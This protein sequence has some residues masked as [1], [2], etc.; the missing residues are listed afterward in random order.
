[1]Y[2]AVPRIRP[3]AV[4]AGEVLVA[5]VSPEDDV[6]TRCAFGKP[7]VQHLDGAVVAHFDV[8]RFQIAMHDAGVVRSRECIG[9][10]TRDGQR[11]RY[12]NGTAADSVGQVLAVHE[13]HGDVCDAALARRAPS[14]RRRPAS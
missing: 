10:L 3:I 11:L 5:A 7:E 9:D 4:K 1:M 2:D 14:G 8:G 12:W 13:L 6:V